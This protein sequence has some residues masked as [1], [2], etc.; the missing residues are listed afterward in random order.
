MDITKRVRNAVEALAGKTDNSLGTSEA[1]KFLRY[2]SGQKP[3]VQNWSD[4]KMSDEDMYTGYSYAAIV[5]RANRTSVLGRRFIMTEASPKTTEEYRARE[6]ELIHPYLKVINRS[7]D[8]T[9]KMFWYEIST[10]L[11]LE[12]VYYLGVVRNSRTRKDGSVMV[13]AVQKFVLLN[14]YEMRRVVKES[15]GEVG[16]YVESNHGF[17]R[18]WSPEQIIEIKMLNPFD[19][20]K[21]YAMSDAAKESQFTLKQAG[22]YTR[23]TINGNI[24]APGIVSTDVLLDDQKFENFKARITGRQK[25]EPIFGNGAGA[26]R[27]QDMQIDL[28]KAALDKINEIQRS[29]LFAVSGTSKTTLGIEESGTTRETSRT[30]DENFTVDSIVPRAE[31]IADA[32]NLDYRQHYDE[33]EDNEF[34][35][36]VDSPVEK[37]RE[38]ELKDIEIRGEVF[39]LAQRLIDKGYEREASFKYANGEITWEELGEPEEPEVPEALQPFAGKDNQPKEGEEDS[40]TDEDDDTDEPDN[41]N[42]PNGKV[43]EN[44]VKQKAENQISARDYQEIYKDL[45]I[46]TDDLGCIMLDLEPMKVLEHLPEGYE[47]GLFE[48]PKWEQGSIPAETVPHVTL[49]YGLLENGNKWKNKVDTLLKDW[50]IDSVKIEEVGYFETPD[51]FAV[52]A[53][54][55]KTPELIDGHE[56]LTLLPHV[57]TFSEYKPHMTLAYV[58]KD[59][60]VDKWVEALGK[61]YNGKTVKSAGINYGDKEDESKAKNH[62]ED[63]HDM[64]KNKKVCKCC[65]GF[66]EHKTGF[67]CYGCDATGIQE[68]FTGEYPCDGREDSKNVWIDEDGDYRHAEERK[69]NASKASLSRVGQDHHSISPTGLILAKNALDGETRDIIKSQENA[70]RNGFAEIERQILETAAENTG[71]KYLAGTGE[72]ITKAQRRR[73][74]QEVEALLNTFYINLYPIFGRQLLAQRGSE[75][76]VIGAYEMTEAAQEYIE[77]MAKKAA[78]SHVNTVLKDIVV[79]ATI[80]Y[81]GLVVAQMIV[82]VMGAVAAGKV[83]VLKK[84]PE[85]PTREIIIEAIEK[86]VFNDSPLYKEAQRLARE[87]EGRDTI[88][89]AIRNKYP[90][91]SKNR[92]TTIARTESARVFNQSQ[93]EADRQFLNSSGLMPRAYKKLRSRTG[94]PCVHCEMLIN[95]PP[96]PFLKNFADLGTTLKATE[97]TEKGDVKVKMLPINWESISAGNVHPNCNCEYVL[98]IKD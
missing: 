6:E 45:D 92:A 47:E 17:Y 23:Q 12:G 7:K 30:Q 77:E 51:S 29:I 19:K 14:P 94:T 22:D 21:P 31:D 82:L 72:P 87:G 10:Y 68:N 27:W 95:Q 70:L 33:W 59:A 1:N 25:G 84:L 46:D 90:E 39:D 4:V 32:L 75:Y 57:N 26:I 76:G 80:A 61:V 38:A 97:T 28:D 34:E 49:L 42:T 58:K 35:I 60:D 16:G 36:I 89:R 71:L 18:E 50:K 93:F 78:A 44:S 3:L 52:V 24:S 81:S 66:G 63:E 65:H 43:E 79:A 56:R 11:D 64:S 5:K 73:F 85:N 91:I 20:E 88:I 96:I 54:L 98:I 74:E 86:G 62:I 40:I 55:E 37:D 9:K 48:N 53:H 69:E 41:T 13:G 67:E 8:F 83:S 2:G 15:T